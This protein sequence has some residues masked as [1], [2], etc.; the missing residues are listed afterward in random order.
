M[1][2]Q[3]Y[4][5]FA[6]HKQ[7]GALVLS[8][9]EDKDDV[10]EDDEHPNA[11]IKPSGL[12]VWNINELHDIIDGELEINV[13]EE[14]QLKLNEVDDMLHE[15]EKLVELVDNNE[16]DKVLLELEV[17]NFG[18]ELD[19]VELE[20]DDKFDDDDELDGEEW[21]EVDEDGFDVD[22]DDNSDDDNVEVDE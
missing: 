11:K 2:N 8:F 13:D 3:L 19:E 20:V 12:L 10:D 5:Y 4:D 17:N 6:L 1:T 9:S 18:E 7:V 21:N 22:E 16:L 14:D 15:D